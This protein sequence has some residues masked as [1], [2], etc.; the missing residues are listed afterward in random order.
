MTVGGAEEDAAGAS[1][2][3]KQ[4]GEPPA[5]GA[6]LVRRLRLLRVDE[7][8]PRTAEDPQDFAEGEGGHERESDAA[9]LLPFALLCVAPFPPEFLSG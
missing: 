3:K 8:G 9:T 7:P 5:A 2:K 6:L 4:G 1:R